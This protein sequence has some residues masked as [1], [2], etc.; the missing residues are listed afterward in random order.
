MTPAWAQKPVG[1]HIANRLVVQ[2]RNS[3]NLSAVNQVLGANGVSAVGQIP[4]INVLVLRV[5]EQ[6]ADRVA[7]ALEHSGQFTFVEKDFVARANT[8]TPNDPYFSSQWHLATIQAP[9]AWDITTGL[10]SITIGV[11]DSGAQPDHPD[12][13]SNLV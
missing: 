2:R 5:P 8:T 1:D 3:A 9:N 10:S 7:A 6:A 13:A 4:Q 11:I 12:L